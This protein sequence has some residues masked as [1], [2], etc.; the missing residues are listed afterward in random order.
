MATGSIKPLLNLDRVLPDHQFLT[1]AFQLVTLGSFGPTTSFSGD[2]WGREVVM[3]MAQKMP[4]KTDAAYMEI[5][6]YNCSTVQNKPF[7]LAC[8]S[9]KSHLRSLWVSEADLFVH[10]HVSHMPRAPSAPTHYKAPLRGSWPLRFYPGPTA[11]LK[12]KDPFCFSKKYAGPRCLIKIFL[13]LIVNTKWYYPAIG[14]MNKMNFFLESNGLRGG[15]GEALRHSWWML[16]AIVVYAVI[17][18]TP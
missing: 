2:L 5:Y 17:H 3:L 9:L 16:K 12:A 8:G 4:Q 14:N 7:T 1:V 10:P 18:V 11:E 6:S 13:F 15:F